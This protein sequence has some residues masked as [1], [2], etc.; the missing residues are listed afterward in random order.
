MTLIYR[1]FSYH[2]DIVILFLSDTR[3]L[4]NKKRNNLKKSE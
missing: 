4:P 3:Y 2:I 1:K